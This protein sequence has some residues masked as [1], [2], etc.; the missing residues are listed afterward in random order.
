MKIKHHHKRKRAWLI[1]YVIGLN[2]IIILKRSKT[3]KNPKQWGLIGGST[4]RRKLSPRK[5]IRKESNEEIGFNPTH[6][7]LV[8]RFVTK[9]SAYYYYISTIREEQLPELRLNYEHSSLKLANLS[10]LRYKKKLHHSIEV[11]LKTKIEN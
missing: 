10:K 3:S 4:S 8:H 5:L 6:L 2:K 7:I 11:Y 9:Q 1:L